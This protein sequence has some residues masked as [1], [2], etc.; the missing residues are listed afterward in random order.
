MNRWVSFCYANCRWNS[1]GSN[2]N[3]CTW[4]WCQDSQIPNSVLF[5][6]NVNR[7][8][9]KIKIIFIYRKQQPQCLA[10]KSA[11][12]FEWGWKEA[13]VQKAEKVLGSKKQKLSPQQIFKFGCF[14]KWFF[15]FAPPRL[16]GKRS[17]TAFGI[18]NF[19][20]PQPH[21]FFPNQN[22]REL[23]LLLV[24][25]RAHN[26]A[27]VTSKMLISSLTYVSTKFAFI[28]YG[29]KQKVSQ[30]IVTC[31]K[32]WKAQKFQEASLKIKIL[33][34]SVTMMKKAW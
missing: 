23:C 1:L 27:K 34:S 11:S 3:M 10:G 21:D 4:W 28:N 12:S 24:P 14:L 33:S 5:K 32:R 8:P 20:R 31:Y 13:K 18:K 17:E 9:F 26:E 19:S 6:A 25:L 16:M 2:L 22:V 29:S 30:W 7:K 15:C